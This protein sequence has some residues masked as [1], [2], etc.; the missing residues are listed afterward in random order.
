MVTE[1]GVRVGWLSCF[2]ITSFFVLSAS[3]ECVNEVCLESPL[4]VELNFVRCFL[5]NVL[6]GHVLVFLSAQF[7]NDH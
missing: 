1:L 2:C 4:R 5:T 3:D 6:M 7:T